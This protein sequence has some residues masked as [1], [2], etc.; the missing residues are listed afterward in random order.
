[1]T[2][3][4]PS[5]FSG[6][7]L[8]L[9]IGDALGM[10]LEGMRASTIRRRL[11]RVREF[12]DAPWRMLKAG[13]WTDD[14]K[15][16]LCHAR[17]ILERKGVDVEDT[18]HKFVEWFES[19]DWRGIGN[20]TYQSIQRL[21]AGVRPGESGARGEMAAGN[22]AA[23]RIA[24][25]GLVDCLDLERLHREVREVSVITHANPE[26]VA[27][28]QAVAFAVALAARGDLDPPSLIAETVRF[29]GPCAVSERL[30]LAERF[31]AEGMEPE[32]ALARLG[33]SGYVVETV[34]SAFFCF[35]RTPGDFEETVSR[36]VEG[37]L[38]A[39]TTGAVAGAISG[40]FNG[41]EGIPERWRQGV[42]AAREIIELAEG[43]YGLVS[44][45]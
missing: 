43:I 38:D 1:M 34:A 40:A 25:V 39:D 31:L 10:P 4:N 41:L 12:M 44:R 36:A 16:M 7:L 3:L 33:T 8:G 17:S 9:A 11:G 5:R 30:L 24:P 15:M 2:E 13:Q 23:M 18:A 32:E 19:G 26:A 6:C 14:T 28:A 29:I 21:R 20:S 35:L 45:N 42:E 37:G 27:G 22:G